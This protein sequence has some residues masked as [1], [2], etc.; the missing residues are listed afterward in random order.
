MRYSTIPEDEIASLIRDLRTVM[1][2]LNRFLGSNEGY[3]H[4]VINHPILPQQTPKQT[5]DWALKRIEEFKEE[6]AK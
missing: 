6:W 3:C 1:T 5:V 4:M 2:N